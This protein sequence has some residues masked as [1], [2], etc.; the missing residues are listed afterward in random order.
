LAGCSST[1]S[2]VNAIES[3][4]ATARAFS[5]SDPLK[6]LYEEIR[7]NGTSPH[8]ADFRWLLLVHYAS[9][10]PTRLKAAYWE[11]SERDYFR[12]IS[13]AHVWLA[14]E[15]C[16]ARK[17]DR[18]SVDQLARGDSGMEG[19][20]GGYDHILDRARSPS[21]GFWW[22]VDLNDFDSGRFDD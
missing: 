17:F 20:Q 16:A 15:L 2:V 14:R 4:A 19:G 7:F 6:S 21:D 1:G 10:D 13:A 8:E 5:F 9:P 12:R 11:L 22:A 18:L 3:A